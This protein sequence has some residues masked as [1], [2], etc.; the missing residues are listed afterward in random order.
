VHTDPVAAQ[1]FEYLRN[2]LYFPNEAKLDPM[3]LPIGFRDFSKGL[4]YY[5]Q[6]VREAS[7]LA[8]DIARGD[9]NTNPLS[10]GNEVAAG[11]KS[12][13]ASLRHLTWQ[14]Q[15]IA[16]GDYKQRVSFMGDFSEA[17]NHMVVQ[18]A[19]RQ[20]ALEIAVEAGEIKS[21][22]L[23]RSIAVFEDITAQMSQ[24]II[25]L[26][27]NTKQELLRNHPLD[28][29]L[30]DS[31]TE[32]Q[33]FEWLGEQLSSDRCA[34]KATLDLELVYT[35][36]F[37]SFL[38]EQHPY[39]WGD[40][41]AVVFVF[42]DTTASRREL[43]CLAEIANFDPLTG[44]YSRHFGM[45]TF[46]QWLERKLSFSLCFIDMDNLKY[47]NDEFGHKEGDAYIL[48]ISRQLATFADDAILCRLGGDEFMLLAR[49]WPQEAA[50]QRLE[51]LREALREKTTGSE[52]NY[53]HS[54]SFGVVGVRADNELSASELLSIADEKMYFYKR[55]H[56]AER[57]T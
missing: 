45:V 7:V 10:P 12:L 13:Q 42:T 29:V 57:M 27:K 11:L 4:L 24:L 8:A 34:L 6:S 48:L 35:G 50:E 39:V 41:E 43:S 19:E 56:K 2:V 36:G 14:T 37:Q 15:Q 38:V 33:L 26:D 20:A 52:A 3:D 28:Q 53:N 55:A 44:S 40:Q 47:V 30:V 51:H 22:A 21:Q 16:K 49:N 54:M 9:L 5:V 1:L 18:L 25:V 31:S 23:Q 17:L 32:E 46:N